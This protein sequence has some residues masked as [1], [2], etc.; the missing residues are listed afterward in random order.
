LHDGDNSIA[1]LTAVIALFSG[2][3]QE[4]VVYKEPRAI[5]EPDPIDI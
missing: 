2:D 3:F 4:A 5:D 1:A